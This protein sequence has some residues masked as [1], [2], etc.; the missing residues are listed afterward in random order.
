MKPW[1]LAGVRFLKRFDTI[2][3]NLDKK[4]DHNNLTL[5]YEE[6]GN[7]ENTLVFLHGLGSTGEVWK[8]QVDQYQE[9]YNIICVDLLGF[10]RSSKELKPEDAL[11]SNV[12]VLSK[13]LSTLRKP[14]LIFG[15]S[16]SG[17]ILSRID[18]GSLKMARGIG[19]LDCMFI[20]EHAQNSFQTWGSSM[21]EK[22]D[23]D[24]KVAAKEWYLGLCG[25]K[26]DSSTNT[27]VKS[28]LGS[29]LRWIFQTAVQVP[30]TPTPKVANLPVLICEAD[31]F[32]GNVWARSFKAHISNAKSVLLNN[33]NHFFF[34]TDPKKFHEAVTPFLETAFK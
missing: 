34:L 1:N 30:L 25:N 31:Q 11:N 7:G 21:L 9:K 29:D 18:F 3:A 4:F 19:F 33:A 14:W 20:D 16:W 22:S 2:G 26:E 24:L 15:H 6:Y 8:N 10:G 17:S 32:F 13:F 27:A 5:A 12:E 28:L 23:A